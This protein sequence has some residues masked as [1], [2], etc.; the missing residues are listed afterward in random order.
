MSETTL[1]SKEIEF[2]IDSLQKI[3]EPRK[4]E[5]RLDQLSPYST[6]LPEVLYDATVQILQKLFDE[7]SPRVIE[8][9]VSLMREGKIPMEI[10]K[11]GAAG[12]Q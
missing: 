4:I 6:A 10:L 11:E 9:L 1:T 7:Y 3:T 8:S 12:G 2:L 5:E